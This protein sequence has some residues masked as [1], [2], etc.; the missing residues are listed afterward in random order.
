[1]TDQ[2]R[3]R[4]RNLGLDN[5]M[6]SMMRETVRQWMFPSPDVVPKRDENLRD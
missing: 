2:I 5:V 6:V 1:M 4:N 3:Q